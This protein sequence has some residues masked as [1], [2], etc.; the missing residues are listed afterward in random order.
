M[1]IHV[2]DS[3][4][5]GEARREAAILAESAKFND[6]ERG[7]L[8]IV[9]TEIVTNLVKHAGEGTVVLERVLENGSSGVRVIGL[10]K[11]P[12]IRDLGV[13]LR[14]GYSSI[15]TA[16]NG[17][18]AIKRLSKVFD[19]YAPPGIGTAVLAELWSQDKAEHRACPMDIAGQS[20]PIAG[21]NIC[22]DG[23]GIKRASD[24]FLLMVVDGLGHGI[25]ASDAS[26]VAEGIL[27]ASTASSP[28]EILR[29]AHE[30]LRKTRGAA[31]A[32]ASLNLNRQVVTFAG[33]GNIGAA[34]VSP[35]ISRSMASHNGTI[36]HHLSTIQEFSF[37]WTTD[38]ILVMYSDGLKSNWD[39]KQY[40]GIWR[41]KSALIAAILWRDFS[42]RRDDVTVLVAKNYSEMSS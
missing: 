7:Q 32:I 18:G 11:G 41:K 38:S 1:I 16:G 13:A 8:A 36:G 28:T 5:A 19:V 12:G 24:T 31:M 9:V 4:H 23:W 3:T 26:R 15:G 21:E 2:T 20:V 14:D 22:G 29:D 37:P 25:L 30:A 27:S 35:V 6:L 34:V 40:P 10:D 42:R 17:L 39:L 33:I